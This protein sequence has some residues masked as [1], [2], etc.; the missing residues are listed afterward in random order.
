MYLPVP[1]DFKDNFIELISSGLTEKQALNTLQLTYSEYLRLLMEDPNFLTQ[2]ESA[3]MARAEIWVGKIIE[4]VD[5]VP[6]DSHGVSVAKLKF[7]KLQFLAKADNPD[8]YGQRGRK[9][10]VN[11]DLNITDYKNLSLDQANKILNNDPFAID[12]E[13]KEV[14]ETKDEEYPL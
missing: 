11:I 12:A 7:E 1:K 8:R 9:S 14:K 3:R 6:A 5:E 4:S 13:F 2:V 10:D